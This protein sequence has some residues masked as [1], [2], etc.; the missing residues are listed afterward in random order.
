MP[1]AYIKFLQKK[2]TGKDRLGIEISRLPLELGQT[3]ERPKNKGG[4]LIA[5]RQ[6]INYIYKVIR[7]PVWN[8][9]QTFSMGER[10]GEL[11]GGNFSIH[12]SFYL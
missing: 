10:S 11:G 5:E 8:I 7:T 4:G 1:K 9:D 12:L 6:C 2:K 3:D